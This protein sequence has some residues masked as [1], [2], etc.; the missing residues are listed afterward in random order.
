MSKMSVIIS[1]DILNWI[2][3]SNIFFFISCKCWNKP[4][5]YLHQT[6]YYVEGN[7]EEGSEYELIFRQGNVQKSYILNI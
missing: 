5:L 4:T 2:D 3:W 1:I 7:C 6:I